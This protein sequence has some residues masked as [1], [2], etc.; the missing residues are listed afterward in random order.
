MNE[1]QVRRI[2][3]E[4]LSK[5][6]KQSKFVFDRPVQ[7]LDGNDII[8][9]Q[10]FGTRIGTSATQKIGFFGVDPVAQQPMVDI[11]SGGATVDQV[12]RDAVTHIIGDMRALGLNATT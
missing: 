7:V 4:E 2:I 8:M 1:E 12:C 3:R 11:P 10:T 9:G 6:M 5:F